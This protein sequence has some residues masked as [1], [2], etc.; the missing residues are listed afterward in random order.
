MTMVPIARTAGASNHLFF[1]KVRLFSLVLV[2][3]FAWLFTGW[4]QLHI[5]NISFPAEL[6]RASAAVVSTFTTVGT[7]NWTAPTGVYSVQYLIVAGGGGGG[8][9]YAGGGGGGEVVTGTSG[10]TPGTAYTVTVGGGGAGGT[11][12]PSHAGNQGGS[13]VFATISA[14]GGGGGGSYQGTAGLNGGSGGGGPGSDSPYS[15]AAGSS[16]K[17]GGGYGN[18]GGS[19]RYGGSSANYNGGGGGGAGGAGTAASTVAPYGAGGPGIASSI[20]GSSVYYGAGGGGDNDTTST[21]PA[22]GGTGGGGTGASRTLAPGA[23]TANTGSGGGGGGRTYNTGGA[24]G[25]GIVIVSYTVSV[26]TLTTSAASSVTSSSATLNGTITATGNANATVRGFQYSTDSTLATGVVTTTES[27][28]F[29]IGAFSAAIAS[30]VPA[31]TYYFRSYATNSAG[32]GYGSIVSFTT[33]AVAPTVTTSAASSITSSGGTLNG[34][35]TATGGAN[36]TQ[37][38]FAYSTNSALSTSVSTSTLGA[39]TG[40]AS[41]SQAVSSLSPNTTYYFRAYATNGVGTG[42]GTIVSFTTSTAPPTITTNAATNVSLDSVT[43]NGA[44][45]ATNGAN[46]ST[47]GFAYGTNASLVTTIATTTD[48]TCPGT[49]GSFTKA[50]ASLTANTLYYFRAYSINTAGTGYGSIQSFM[51]TTN[52]TAPIVTTLAVSSISSNGAMFNGSIAVTGG[53]TGGGTQHGF[54]Y[55]TDAA[56][57]SGVSTTTLGAYFT[58]NTFQQSRRSLSAATTYYVRAYASNSAGTGYGSI[59]GFSTSATPFGSPPSRAMRLF[60]GFTVRVNGWTVRIY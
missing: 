35:I 57:V 20:S 43:L 4:P 18:A 15:I 42:Y 41:F 25:S 47:C 9:C 38:G 5:G 53:G 45:S 32:T 44:I 52:P 14:N 12:C 59:Q 31:T 33:S 51:T 60:Q 36:A 7:T 3:A 6:P 8:A 39:Q 23:G 21:S 1:K 37:S 55:S 30:L 26:P 2:L 40:T 22:N 27:G 16:V 11:G 29:G 10:V 13:S 54:A 19:G 46:A 24:G 58:A 17:T 34:S 48:S 56:L 50:L 49:T 28:S